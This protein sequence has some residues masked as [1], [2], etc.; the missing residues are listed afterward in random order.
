MAERQHRY[1]VTVRWTG[2]LGSGTSSYKAY[3]RD[4]EIE[5]AGEPPIPGS[6]DPAFRG[7]PARW[8]PEQLFV[9]SVSAC[10]KLWYLH[11]AAVAGIVVTAYVD[12][13]EGSMV[14]DG[15][16]AGHFVSITLRPEI[17]VQEPVDIAKAQALHTEAHA[18]CFIANSIKTPVA[19]EPVFK[20]AG[21]D[22]SKT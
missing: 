21:S 11:L 2:N 3:A 10:H 5:A 22:G 12:R 9:A 13:A 6:S 17:A 1:Q 16:G 18:K 19:V 7:D 4:H 20:T 14:E 15:T 8:N